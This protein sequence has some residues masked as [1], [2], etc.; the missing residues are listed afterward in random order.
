MR[1]PYYLKKRDAWYVWHEGRQVRLGKGLTEEQAYEE[2]KKLDHGLNISPATP[3]ADLLQNF[4]A[5]VQINRSPATAVW[6][7]NFLT[8]FGKTVKKPASDIRPYDVQ[9]WAD[10]KYG[11]SSP[12]TRHGAMRAV[13]RVFAWAVKQGLF[14]HNPLAGMEKPTPNRREKIITAD[15]WAAIMEKETKVPWRDFLIFL[16]ETGCRV[17]EARI[18]EAAHF[19]ADYGRFIIPASQVKGKRSPRAIYLSESALEIAKRRI[20]EYPTGPIFRNTR[21]H[22]LSRNAIRC[23][24]RGYGDGL[25]ATLLRHTYITEALIKGHDSVTLAVLCGHSDPS[26]IARTYQKLSQDPKY[27]RSLATKIR[28][29]ITISGAAKDDNQGPK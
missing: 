29:P 24:F 28:E 22:P 4:F 1:K 12:S 13:Q 16:R 14:R 27:L 26:M 21:K 6:Y 10:N 23:R 11:N 15:Q 17:Q 7:E 9:R 8:S 20:A 5:W 25:C 18:L 2:W 3:V 19:D